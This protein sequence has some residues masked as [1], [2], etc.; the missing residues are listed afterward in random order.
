MVMKGWFWLVAPFVSWLL[1]GQKVSVD[2][3]YFDWLISFQRM[4]LIG[5]KNV[6]KYIFYHDEWWV[7]IT[8]VFRLIDDIARSGW[9][10]SMCLLAVLN[11]R[12]SCMKFVDVQI[13]Q[14]W[15]CLK[16][17]TLNNVMWLWRRG[18]NGESLV[19]VPITF[20]FHNFS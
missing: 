8:D 18:G 1:I 4:D 13:M 17:F 11:C 9:N 10:D 20:I 7:R 3:D 14:L 16:F 2:E 19:I 12:S 6:Q 15:S 5:W